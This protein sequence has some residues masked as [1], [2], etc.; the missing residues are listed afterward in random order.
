MLTASEVISCQKRVP[1]TLVMKSCQSSIQAVTKFYL[2]TL[3]FGTL[4]SLLCLCLQHVLGNSCSGHAVVCGA[5]V[6][7]TFKQS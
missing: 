5:L 3:M 4:K 1:L 2:K 7:N 6:P